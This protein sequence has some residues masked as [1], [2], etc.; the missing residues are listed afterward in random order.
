MSEWYTL[1]AKLQKLWE[2]KRITLQSAWYYFQP[3]TRPLDALHSL[4]CRLSVR[5]ANYNAPCTGAE[6][7]NYVYESLLH[8][9][10][11]SR[12]HGL[13]QRLLK[14]A[15]RPYMHALYTWLSSGHVD[16]K[17]GEFMIVHNPQ[18]AMDEEA[19]AT[20]LGTNDRRTTW[21]N[22]YTIREPVPSFL[23][24]LRLQL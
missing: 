7:I 5:E 15:S 2:D 1:G 20:S 8:N 11:D 22:M 3:I 14:H 21:T 19:R 18:K 16:D 6:L 23:S 17:H 13:L 24:T 4:C 9:S 10:G 12:V